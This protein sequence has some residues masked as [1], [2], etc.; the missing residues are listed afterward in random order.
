MS[1]PHEELNELERQLWAAAYGAAFAC[2]A[3]DETT[4]LGKRV[5]PATEG[6]AAIA[7]WYADL[8]VR[9]RRSCGR[10]PMALGD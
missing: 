4:C 7:Y 10:G 9:A 8:A 2:V 1:N 3:F 5:E 6:F